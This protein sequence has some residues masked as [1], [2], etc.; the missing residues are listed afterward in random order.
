MDDA[1]LSVWLQLR[2]AADWRARSV[3]LTQAIVETLLR[4]RSVCVLDLAAG[5]GSNLR[6]LVERLPTQQRWLLV[7]RSA[8]LLS[9]AETRTR[10]WAAER[11]YAV[12]NDTREG[13]GFSVAGPRLDCRVEMRAQDLGSLDDREIFAGRHLV[14]ASA[15][16]DLVS[17]TWLRTLAS[18]CRGAGAAALF[19]ITYDGRFSCAPPE[20]EDERVR[21]LMNEHQR[22]DK[23]LGGPAEGPDAAACAMR[24]F[25]D[26]GYQVTSEAS[27]WVLAPG[28]AAMQHALIDG[29]AEAASEVTPGDAAM[30][31]SWRARRLAH[32][33]E[34]TS[35][36]V[37]GHRDVAAWRK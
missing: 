33:N 35:H 10:A 21:G 5:A 20:P 18:R 28:D 13:A 31:A 3:A 34:G 27:D 36:L 32:V 24:C 6:Y 17:E 26:E 2:E 22:R 8:A 29:W 16:L 9:E 25:A 14:T 12:D 19:T 11:G 30:V 4:D 7:D 37:V 15:L 23:G 1:A